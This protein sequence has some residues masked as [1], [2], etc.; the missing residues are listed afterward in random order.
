MV[1]EYLIMRYIARGEKIIRGETSYLR[2]SGNVILTPSLTSYLGI[3][4]VTPATKIQWTAFLLGGK[5]KKYKHSKHC[6]EQRKQVSPVVF[7][8]DRML[9]KEDQFLL[10]QLSRLMAK[11]LEEQVSRVRG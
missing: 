8:I 6:Y 5:I 1:T 3:P 9:V 2:G 10:K 4:T 7:S 11:K